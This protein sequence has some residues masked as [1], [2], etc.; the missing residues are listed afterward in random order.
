MD[1][2]HS[3][4][5]RP[6]D[7]IGKISPRKEHIVQPVIGC[8]SDI[9]PWKPMKIQTLKFQISCG[10]FTTGSAC[11]SLLLHLTSD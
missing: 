3:L 10:V 7:S 11:P 4:H 5:H 6:G 1:V 8:L 2:N 9:L